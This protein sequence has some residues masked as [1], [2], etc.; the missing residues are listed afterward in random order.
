MNFGP[1]PSQDDDEDIIFGPD[2]PAPKAANNSN[3]DLVVDLIAPQK[4]TYDGYHQQYQ[5]STGTTSVVAS[6]ATSGAVAQVTSKPISSSAVALG[7]G[8]G[9]FY[10][11]NQAL[12]LLE[13]QHVAMRIAVHTRHLKVT[14]KLQLLKA[15]EGR[16]VDINLPDGNGY[17]AL[18]SAATIGD[19]TSVHFFLSHGAHVNA[20]TRRGYSPL[21]FACMYGHVR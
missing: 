15:L 12:P 13:Q 10:G 8:E 14:N 17:T 5:G 2:K 3:R 19:E 6:T 20:Q 4:Q 21:M 11:T 16:T 9:G 18:H 1:A 7:L